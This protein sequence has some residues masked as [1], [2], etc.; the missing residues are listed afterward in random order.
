[1]GNRQPRVTKYRPLDRLIT[2][3]L[4]CRVEEPA[5]VEGDAPPPQPPGERGEH[6]GL[7]R[8]AGALDDEQWL[9][10]GSGAVFAIRQTANP[11]CGS[12]TVG[13]SHDWQ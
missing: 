11:W 9:N 6:G 1:M 7:P 3:E 5:D 4:A 2:T 10:R 8:T 13:L 12:M